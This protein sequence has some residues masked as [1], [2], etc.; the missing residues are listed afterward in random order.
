MNT[1]IELT[2]NNLLRDLKLSL[3]LTKGRVLN[4]SN[5]ALEE[6]EGKVLLNYSFID[7]DH[8]DHVKITARQAGDCVI[9]SLDAAVENEI[10]S[11]WSFNAEK[12][13]TMNFGRSIDADVILGSMHP[14]LSAWWTFPTW[15]SL[16]SRLSASS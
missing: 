6:S 9:F 2:K 11:V 13:V 10:L 5:Y 16:I 14:Y 3:N 1:A 8:L 15:M 12:A 7:K 4:L